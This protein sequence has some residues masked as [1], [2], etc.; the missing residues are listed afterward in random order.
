MVE[1]DVAAPSTSKPQLQTRA[2]APRTDVDK[3]NLLLDLSAH[4]S[5][6]T[7][8]ERQVLVGLVGFSL[9]DE[10][11][12]LVRVTAAIS[13][14]TDPSVYATLITEFIRRQAGRPI[15]KI[16]ESEKVE[17][18]KRKLAKKN[19]KAKRVQSYIRRLKES[20]LETSDLRD[21]FHE[22][23]R[24]CIAETKRYEEERTS[25]AE[26][27]SDVE[28]R[29]HDENREFMGRLDSPLDTFGDGPTTK[30]RLVKGTPAY[31]EEK[32]R[33]DA[34]LDQYAEQGNGVVDRHHCG[35]EFKVHKCGCFIC[36]RCMHISNRAPACNRRHV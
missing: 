29:E 2:A 16:V 31:D 28:D 13:R 24:F 14:S 5:K 11:R 20:A 27:F 6:F 12:D 19:A 25:A 1:T 15:P 23:N 26:T 4:W 21:Y 7:E 10:K 18:L 35:G 33:L 32:A 3:T 36:R 34:E 22:I 17:K 8:D 9:G 30:K